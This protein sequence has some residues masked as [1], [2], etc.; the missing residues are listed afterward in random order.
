MQHQMVQLRPEDRLLVRARVELARLFSKVIERRRESGEKGNDV[1]Q[2]LPQ[3][4]LPP[5]SRNPQHAAFAYL[6][7]TVL[8]QRVHNLCSGTWD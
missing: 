3:L 8:R 5:P 2:V 4:R 6:V 7:I 1:L